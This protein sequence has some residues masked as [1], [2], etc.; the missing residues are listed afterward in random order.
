MSLKALN[1]VFGGKKYLVIQ[2]GL[3]KKDAVYKTML[4]LDKQQLNASNYIIK[5]FRS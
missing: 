1:I 5:H 2:F 3:L 4:N